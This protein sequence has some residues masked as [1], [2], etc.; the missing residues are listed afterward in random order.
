MVCVKGVRDTH[1]VATQKTSNDHIRI[2][3][4]VFSNDREFAGEMIKRVSPE[5]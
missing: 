4:E 5:N 1:P 3:S 2:G